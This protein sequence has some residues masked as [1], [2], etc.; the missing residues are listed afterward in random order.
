MSYATLATFAVAVTVTPPADAVQVIGPHECSSALSIH[1]Q[2][3]SPI[4]DTGSAEGL[5][6]APT[7]G[8][9]RFIE[10]TAS[11]PSWAGF[12]CGGAESA[13]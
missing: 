9:T 3:G 11:R 12:T 5:G 1:N 4:N 7:V 10:S 13:Q 2:V 6:V 8:A